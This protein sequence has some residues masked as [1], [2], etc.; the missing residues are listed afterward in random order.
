MSGEAYSA[1]FIIEDM[2]YY[3]K[4]CIKLVLLSCLPEFPDEN[5]HDTFLENLPT[6][7]RANQKKS[8]YKTNW[9]L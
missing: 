5:L 7:Q 8:E 2:V 3:F 6:N 1:L 9:T 4:V